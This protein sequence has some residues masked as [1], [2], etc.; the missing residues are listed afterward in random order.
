MRLAK[1]K[2]TAVCRTQGIGKDP[3]ESDIQIDQDK[4][5]LRDISKKI[6]PKV[7]WHS[8]ILETWSPSVLDII[9][10]LLFSHEPFVVSKACLCD[11]PLPLHAFEGTSWRESLLC[12]ASLVLF[13]HPF[14]SSLAFLKASFLFK[15][16]ASVLGLVYLSVSCFV[17]VAQLLVLPSILLV[18]L[19]APR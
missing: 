12:H 17:N 13:A 19:Q 9:Q 6:S 15:V 4:S 10:L 16:Q 5:L 3:L 14:P 2:L 8:S 1:L 11:L 7:S 18:K